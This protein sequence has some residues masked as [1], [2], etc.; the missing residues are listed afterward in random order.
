MSKRMIDLLFTDGS[1]ELDRR[2]NTYHPW[3][4]DTLRDG[5][6]ARSGTRLF[7]D[8]EVL[9][10]DN[11]TRYLYEVCTQEVW[12]GEDYPNCAPPF[13]T[14]WME[15]RAPAYARSGAEVHPWHGQHA[16]G[17]LFLASELPEDLGTTL[18]NPDM[19]ARITEQMKQLWQSVGKVFAAHHQTIPSTPPPSEA[20]GRAWFA[21]LPVECQNALQQYVL[22]QRAL[23]GVQLTEPLQAMARWHYTVFTF[24]HMAP[25]DPIIGPVHYGTTL[26]SSTG[27]LVPVPNIHGTLQDTVWG[28]MHGEE[29]SA[30][31]GAN[32]AGLGNTLLMPMW[33]ALSFLHCKNVSTTKEDPC[34]SRK[35]P[36]P[37]ERCRRLHYHVLNIKPMQEVLR[38]EGQSQTTGL[39]KAL[40]ICR[41]HFKDYQ[42]KG[43]FGKYPGLF[44]WDSHIRGRSE[45]GITVKDYAISTP[46]LQGVHDL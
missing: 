24:V 30:E 11:V 33:L 10:V 17:A 45:Q 12:G 8:A 22:A 32:I 2:T 41:G 18:Q 19:Q 20:A 14:F 36:K 4:I 31:E 26:V 6:A 16:W 13:P 23:E 25:H 27:Q 43:L 34:H 15:T 38:R 29:L 46:D 35:P 3:S 44:W 9:V 1:Q 37:G 39:K 5:G 42:Q 40:H 21:A 7:D 28:V